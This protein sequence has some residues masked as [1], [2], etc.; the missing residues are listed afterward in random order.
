M[1]SAN[2]FRLFP[3]GIAARPLRGCCVSLRFTILGCGSSGGVPRIGNHWGACDPEEPRNRRL[4]CSLLH[5]ARRAG[6]TTPRA[7]RYRAGPA[8][9]A[10]GR[11]GVEALDAVLYTHEHADHT[12][13][14]DELRVVAINMRRRVAAFAD[15]RTA[16][17]LRTRFGYCFEA[18]PGSDYPPIITLSRLAAG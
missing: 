18:P 7:D 15:D 3:Q 16:G 4:R 17:M 8:G 6:G 14:I 13:G 12:H 1:S 11:A 9:A 5:R 10:A 2:F